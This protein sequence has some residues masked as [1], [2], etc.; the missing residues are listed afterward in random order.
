MQGVLSGLRV[1]ELG[2]VLAGPF[3]GAIFG[4]LGAEVVKLER[5]D[6]GDDGRRMGPAF[7]GDDSLVFQVRKENQ[8]VE[9]QTFTSPD[10]ARAFFDDRVLDLGSFTTG[11]TQTLDLEISFS[12]TAKAAGAGWNTSYL[13]GKQAGAPNQWNGVNNGTFGSASNWL[14]NAVPTGVA[15]FLGKATGPLAVNVAGPTT[16]RIPARNSPSSPGRSLWAV[17]VAPL[18]AHGRSRSAASASISA[19]TARAAWATARS[20]PT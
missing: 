11:V 12:L 10:Q 20:G 17:R 18:S 13:F 19:S 16:L 2:Q 15:S 8:L 5:A 1:L 7:H 9:N 14:N 6:G 4:D 3:A